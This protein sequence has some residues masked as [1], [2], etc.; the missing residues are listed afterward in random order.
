M[1]QTF[2]LARATLL[3]L[4]MLCSIGAW[5]QSNPTSYDELVAAINNVSSGGTVTLGGDFAFTGEIF[6]NKD[7]TIDLNGHSLTRTV[8]GTLFNVNE[9]KHLT[10]RATGGGN[11][12]NT[13]M[14]NAFY[15][16][17]NGILTVEGG[18]ISTSNGAAINNRGTTYI[19][20]G[21]IDGHSSAL[22]NNGTMYIL[23]GTIIGDNYGNSVR[24]EGSLYVFT[25]A[26][27]QKGIDE[28][29]GTVINVLA[30][31]T[32][33]DASVTSYYGSMVEAVTGATA[34]SG[35]TLKLWGDVDLSS[36]GENFGI[37]INNG[38]NFTLDLNGH[39]ID[40]GLTTPTANGGVIKV[41]VG[42]NLTIKDSQGG[43]TI[44]GGNNSYTTGSGVHV[45]GDHQTSTG[46]TLTLEGGIITGNT[47]NYAV[48]IG[49][50][51]HFTMTG[52]TIT[53]NEGSGVDAGFQT[54]FKMSGGSITSNNLYGIQTNSGQPT[55]I[56]FAGAPVVTGNGNGNLYL[57]EDRVFTISGEMTAGANIG[58]TTESRPTP[59]TPVALSTSNAYV[60]DANA[61]YFKAD[62][63]G[64]NVYNDEGTLKMSNTFTDQPT[65]E[66][67]VM[68]L[69]GNVDA[70]AVSSYKDEV[71]SVVCAPGTMLPGD[72]WNLFANFSQVQT[73]D[74]SNADMSHVTN[75]SYMFYNCSA[76]TITF[77][78]NLQ[79]ATI[80]DY[81]F[82]EC[83][84]LT[85]I[86]I[87][88]SVTSIGNK[89]FDY[90][91]NLASVYVMAT[92]PPT[93]GTGAFY[94]NAD[95]RKIYVPASSVGDSSSPAPG[96]YK[97]DWSAY[98]SYIF[99][100]WTSGNCGT[101]G[102]ENSVTWSYN[103]T[104]K[105][106]TIS[107]TGQM[108]YYG[109]A[110]GGD[111]KYHSTAPWSYL[112]SE[113]QKV[114][115]EDGV[116]YI[117]SYAF[118][119]CTALTSVSL[120]AS[121][122]QMGNY[123]CCYDSKLLRIDIPNATGVVSLG[124]GGFD[125]TPSGLVIA[126][127]AN[128][129]KTYKGTTNW[130]GYAAKLEGVL[131]ETTGFDTNFAT[132]NYEYKRTF[133]CGVAATL[134]LPFELSSAQISP[135]GT[136]YTF[137]GVDKTTEPKWTVVMQ[138]TDP[139]NLVTG[140]LAANTPYLFVPYILA[141]KSKGDAM[142]LI[143][144]GEVA[145]AANAGYTSKAEG[146]AGA[147][148]TFQGV[149]YNVAWNDGNENLGKV[150]GFA[151]RDYTNVNP[152]DFVKAAAGA[153]IAP[154]RA[155]LQYT[156]APSNAPRRGVADNEVLPSRMSV[157]LV[158]AD[159]TVTAIGTMDTKTGE[160]RFDN[161][162]WYTLDGRRL[163]STPGTRGIYIK[164][165]KKIILK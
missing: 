148:W 110:L 40:R 57:D 78:D 20:D 131:S 69:Q 139:S 116:T 121:V 28:V 96:T 82:F 13:G 66:N 34:A 5:A 147:Y 80:G 76:Q 144:T 111:N 68:T 119:Y 102:S 149:Y 129:L 126:V 15:V 95:G 143:F 161:D 107:G 77:A 56:K 21:T 155:F 65:V 165:G 120:P 31:V 156:P 9:N 42:G 127:P 7:V 157:R 33:S 153:S 85:S 124:T 160:V 49:D 39:T 38:A 8:D 84:S 16:N 146:T 55:E 106:L 130:S 60:T 24:N 81:A 29:S 62:V 108:M 163:N 133:N 164:N 98:A 142:P 47:G 10:I 36:I 58:I 74:L 73:I 136:V 93:L 45:A 59:T 125:D 41:E 43:G 1:K 72:C 112:D 114:I 145:T 158:N 19:Y 91:S 97:H 70:S 115:V 86:T 83:G 154:F 134:C 132:G 30:S 159:G 141:G 64:Y 105:T 135:Y 88:A 12:T 99:P 17:N 109:S 103:P 152:G 151:A 117:G 26:T 44:T 32:T 22:S 48:R 27:L 18:N 122:I 63:Y 25:G 140:N 37:I 90:C 118:A 113:I 51:A 61:A 46:G 71:T 67:G 162:A 3:L 101:T 128:L 79:I 52:G 94:G 6:I 123:V 53:G 137:D 100:Y 54:V 11:V 50:Y 138:E 4:V 75:I 23:G 92:T 14:G 150:Y 104:T 89:A 2:C 87:P 35:S